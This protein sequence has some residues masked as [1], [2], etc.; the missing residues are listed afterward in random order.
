MVKWHM[1]QWLNTWGGLLQ[2]VVWTGA[3]IGFEFTSLK[4]G[5]CDTEVRVAPV[6]SE[7]Y[8]VY[9]CIAFTVHEL[10]MGLDG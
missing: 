4:S 5:S 3:R 9:F 1:T 7:F 6:L 10:W 2:Y 8:F